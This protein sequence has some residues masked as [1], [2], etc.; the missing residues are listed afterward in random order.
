MA[1]DSVKKSS[2]FLQGRRYTH[3]GSLD[4]QEA[5]TSVL[6][7]NANEV[8]VD[9][10]L[11]PTASLPFSGSSQDQAIYSVSGSNVLKYYYR[12]KMT[13]SNLATV[14]TSE[15]WFFLDPFGTDT[16]IGSQVIDANQQVNFISPKYSTPALSN[17]ST[18][19]SVPGYKVK[20][21]VSTNSST[22]AD[23]DAVSDNNFAFDYKTGVL[24]FSASAPASTGRYVYVTAYQY[25]GKTL[26][27]LSTSLT[28]S[29]A[30]TASYAIN[31]GAGSGFPFSGSAVITGSLIVVNTSISESSTQPTIGQSLQGGKVA[32]ILTASDAGY[33][34]NYYKG[35]IAADVDYQPSLGWGAPGT[36][37][38]A[39]SSLI[40]YGQINTNKILAVAPYSP[41]AS[42]SDAYVT[43]GY[44][45][46]YLP[47]K[48]ELQQL[49]NNSASIGGFDN[50]EYYWSSTE[51]DINQAYILYFG[52][53]TWST[54]VKD[55][56]Y[57]FRPV[58]SF[59]IAKTYTTNNT[60]NLTVSGSINVTNGITGSLQGTASYA[61]TA[62]Y[63][64]NVS[65][66]GV[67][68]GN[69]GEFQYKSGLSLLGSSNLSQSGSA[70]VLS[71][72]LTSK[73]S[74]TVPVI[75]AT[76]STNVALYA[77]SATA[78]FPNFS[79]MIIFTNWSNSATTLAMCGG[80]QVNVQ[81]FAGSF[82][83]FG[84]WSYSSGTSAYVWT[85]TTGVN[86]SASFT[87][88]K[89]KNSV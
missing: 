21:F 34:A 45:D 10:N 15:V 68:T 27:S 70:L 20:V 33:D 46:W 23:G 65:G 76:P 36:L 11:I 72:S 16:G 84:A 8:Y 66:A 9:Q 7:I 89:T 53:N 17:A 3:S 12:K 37:T 26:A 82:G 69:D 31:A 25:I 1:I 59:S 81:A 2:R 19:D 13:K 18:E 35:I 80:N 48:D 67:P 24:E 61:L 39:T 63:V 54:P 73:A 86:V 40:G 83:N 57:A 51:Y 43:G 29:Y 47:S 42:A 50:T 14:G 74:P 62:S 55:D 56:I 77:A 52:N 88:I 41:A 85:N 30:T 78:S 32:Y 87:A 60:G 58:R 4:F 6:D 64:L 28:A 5:F 49:Y 38:S 75:D 71:G 79:G 44:S 22:P